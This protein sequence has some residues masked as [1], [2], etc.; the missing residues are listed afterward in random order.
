VDAREARELALLAATTWQTELGAGKAR[1]LERR[2]AEGAIGDLMGGLKRRS[3]KKM[4]DRRTTMRKGQRMLDIRNAR[5]LP[6]T[7]AELLRLDAFCTAL[8]KAR[9]AAPYFKFRDAA[10]RIAGTGSLGIA[11]YVILVEGEGSP[12]G[13]VLLDLK[14]ATPSSL[15]D[16][17]RGRQPKWDD[18][19][20]RVVATQRNCQAVSPALLGAVTYERRSFVIKELQPSADRLELEDTARDRPRLADVIRSMARLAA[21]GQIRASGHKAAA[22]ADDLIAFAEAEKETPA[23]LLAAARDLHAVVVADYRDFCAACED[24]EI[25]SGGAGAGG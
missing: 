4:L 25:A 6:A 12:D 17:A 15:A 8:G 19:G 3:Q 14:Q 24:G 22:P 21:W 9:D 7:E 2:T 5:M 23:R 10:R 20:M 18:D 11:R 16:V 1:W 13:N